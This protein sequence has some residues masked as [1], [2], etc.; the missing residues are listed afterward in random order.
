MLPFLG[1]LALPPTKKRLFGPSEYD[2]LVAYGEEVP[3]KSKV[4]E[5]SRIYLPETFYIFRITQNNFTKTTVTSGHK[6]NN[7]FTGVFNLVV[8]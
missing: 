6:K 1:P 8:P 4:F 7:V 3:C 2:F 5:K